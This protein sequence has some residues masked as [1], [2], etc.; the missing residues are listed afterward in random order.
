MGITSWKPKLNIQL[1]Y[2]FTN[3]LAFADRIGLKHTVP[4]FTT[5]SMSMKSS[6]AVPALKG[7]AH[8]V[9]VVTEW[10]AWVSQDLCD[11]SEYSRTRAA[12]SWAHHDSVTTRSS[13]SHGNRQM[14]IFSPRTKSE[15]R[16]LQVKCCFLPLL[17]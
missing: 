3:F 16:V 7:K 9:L 4:Q 15:R 6:G 2:A 17:R 11:G 10:V 14:W 8:N 5:N 12:C 13:R 1:R